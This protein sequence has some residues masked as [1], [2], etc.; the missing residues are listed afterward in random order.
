MPATDSILVAREESVV[1]VTLNRPERLNA[2]DRA[3]W[4][5]LATTFDELDVDRTVRCIVVRG[6]GGRAFGAGADI[7]EFENERRDSAQAAAYGADV[8]AAMGAIAESVH[9]TIA[10]IEG[11]CVGGGLEIACACDLRVCGISSRF[12]I[13]VNRLGLTMAY[14]ELRALLSVVSTPFAR[15]ML[16]SGELFDAQRAENMGLVN[17]V[18]DDARVGEEAYA[19]AARVAAGAPLVNRLH[20]KFIA[21][22]SDP[23][24]LTAAETAEGFAAFDTEDFKRGCRAFLDKREPDFEGD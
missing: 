2:L 16:F 4:Q 11:L 6:A 5:H 12:G 22:L 17:R 10:L 23:K 14:G 9:P 18:V 15:E 8:D 1:T 19:L 21:R 7:S 20:K 3:A 13:P 24:P